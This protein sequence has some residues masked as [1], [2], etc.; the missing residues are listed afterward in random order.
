MTQSRKIS[1]VSSISALAIKVSTHARAHSSAE[2]QVSLSLNLDSVLLLASTS[3]EASSEYGPT[4]FGCFRKSKSNSAH[5]QNGVF[6]L[7]SN[8]GAVSRTS[9]RAEVADQP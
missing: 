5:V 7:L 2:A 9:V 3:Q 4:G 8:S 6:R 1:L